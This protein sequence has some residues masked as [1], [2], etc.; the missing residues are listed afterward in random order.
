MQIDLSS[1]TAWVSDNSKL[2]AAALAGAI[3]GLAVGANAQPV[4]PSFNLCT[5]G[6][7][8]NYFFAGNV[9]RKHSTS[10]S[11]N[12]VETRGSIDNMERIL[13]G[14]CDGAFV[15]TDALRVYGD[16]N[17]RIISSIERASVL[18]EEYVH[19]L[20]NRDAKLGRVT[21]LTTKHTVAVGP[22]GSGSAVS[23]QSFVAA[24]KKKYGAIPT[25]PRSGVR[26][27]NA[28]A[29]G[30]QVQCMLFT[31]ALKPSLVVND[32]A[33]LSKRIVMVPADDRDFGDAKDQRGR[34]IYNYREIPAN[35]Y[36]DLQPSAALFGTKAVD[37]V[38]VEAVFVVSTAW[39][40]QY[41]RSY[42]SLLRAVIAARPEI[43]KK[44]GQ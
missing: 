13:A 6:E 32:A 20:C 9:V 38:A 37:T 12:V 17:P 10:V 11:V 15:Q 41:E 26:A 39:I 24:D 33:P 14:Q 8:G 35:L 4:K 5:G 21:D 2:L 36:G 44:V 18:Y 7:S 25:D 1:F 42:D 31:S 40:D 19:L 30:T 16:K 23:W 43:L 27:L 34:R 28:V 3:I 29:D 22:D